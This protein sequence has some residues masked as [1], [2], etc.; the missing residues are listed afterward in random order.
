VAPSSVQT[1][2]FGRTANVSFDQNGKAVVVEYGEWTP[3]GDNTFAEVISPAVAGMVA[4]QQSVAAMTETQPAPMQLRVY[5]Y[6]ATATITPDQP[7]QPGELVDPNNPTGPRYPAGL[8]DADLNTVATR[9]ITFVDENGEQL[10][11]SITQTIKFTRTA[12]VDFQAGTVEYGHWTTEQGSFAK[13]TSPEI[14]GMTADQGFVPATTG[15]PGAALQVE[16]V[17]HRDQ[18]PLPDTNGQPGITLPSTFGGQTNNGNQTNDGKKSTGKQ[19][20]SSK[21][22]SARTLLPQTGNEHDSL[23]SALG[24][25]LATM[26]G[27]FGLAKKHKRDEE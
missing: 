4:D 7:K 20:R 10:A 14:T 24:L 9:T 15:E 8:T 27:L 12:T 3:M 11:D 18:L 26:L 21:T 5:Y 25:G 6:A 19:N 1:I 23:L 22:D 17:Y 16:V 2:K 13:V